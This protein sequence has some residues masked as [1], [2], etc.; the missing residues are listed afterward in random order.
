MN[1]LKLRKCTY[2]PYDL[3]TES[4]QLYL[5]LQAIWQKISKCTSNKLLHPMGHEC[6]HTIFWARPTKVPDWLWSDPI[7]LYNWL[8]QKQLNLHVTDLLFWYLSHIWHGIV[9]VFMTICTDMKEKIV[10]VIVAC[11]ILFRN[12]NKSNFVL[13]SLQI[14]INPETI[15]YQIMA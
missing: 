10:F 9:P 7:F 1:K 11:L 6:W 5:W 8:T 4:Q 15:R 2:L 14:F 12:N 3:G 13:I